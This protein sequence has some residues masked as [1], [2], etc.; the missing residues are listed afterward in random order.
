MG[1]GDPLSTSSILGPHSPSVS[2]SL[3]LSLCLSL[4]SST[5]I[6]GWWWWRW[7]WR[8]WANT[9]DLGG[10]THILSANFSHCCLSLLCAV[11]DHHLLLRV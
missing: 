4:S 11:A 5:I 9:C 1:G 3:H 8:R 10:G 6:P 2:T 7:C